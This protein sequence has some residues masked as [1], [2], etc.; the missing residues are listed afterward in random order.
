M[1]GM[2]ASESNAGL[3]PDSPSGETV[4]K[5]EGKV[6]GESAAG[7]FTTTGTSFQPPPRGRRR[8]R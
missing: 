3:D 7:S 1:F 2:C 6:G 8:R 4:D 5:D